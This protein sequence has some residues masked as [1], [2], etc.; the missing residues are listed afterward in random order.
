MTDPVVVRG[1]C[2]RYRTDSIDEMAAMNTDEFGKLVAVEANARGARFAYRLDVAEFGPL[3][4]TDH[5]VSAGTLIRSDRDD[6]Y[7]VVVAVDGVVSFEQA[8]TQVGTSRSRGVT[9]SPG[10]GTLRI[11]TAGGTRLRGLTI[12]R[13]VWRE[14]LSE[15]L[16]RTVTGPGEIAPALDVSGEPG[17]RWA[18]LLHLVMND[19]SAGGLLTTHPLTAAPLSQAL[20]N[21]LLLAAE[22]EHTAH[23]RQQA[24]PCRPRAVQVAID[25]MQ[26]DPAQP[27][28]PRTLAELAGVGT[29]TLQAGFRTHLG[30]T[31]TGYLR[32]VRLDRVH[33]DLR[34][35]FA[36]TVTEAAHRWGFTHLGRFAAQYR[37]R[38]GRSPSE[39]LRRA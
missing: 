28:T 29:R 26:A 24:A 7:G 17:R 1:R 39:T 16:Q 2:R 38:Y 27:Y 10:R 3:Q 5:A 21:G 4:L 31:P 36:E 30:V 37:Q 33:R 13:E 15:L 25:A 9:T 14:Q 12:D 6:F 19:L 20:L 34:F 11:R 23:L 18:E 32:D 22:H 8:G 35:G